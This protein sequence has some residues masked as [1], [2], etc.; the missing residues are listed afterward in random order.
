MIGRFHFWGLCNHP[1][2]LNPLTSC[3][4]PEIRDRIRQKMILRGRLSWIRDSSI[5]RRL[6]S[7]R[8]SSIRRR[9]NTK[10]SIPIIYE[11]KHLVVAN[12]P[13]GVL[14]QE[15]LTGRLYRDDESRRYLRTV[16]RLD[17]VVSGCICVG[18]SSKATSR[19][20]D[21][22]RSRHVRKKYFA[23]VRGELRKDSFE[24]NTLI[25]KLSPGAG[26]RGLTKESCDSNAREAVLM[27]EPIEMIRD[28]FTNEPCTLLD[29]TLVTGI[30]HQ[31][32]AQLASIGHHIINDTRYDTS[33]K[34]RSEYGV[35]AL[36]SYLL[37]FDHPVLG[38][39]PVI[40]QCEIPW[41][42]WQS[43][44]GLTQYT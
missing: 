24:S 39:D 4:T 37:S 44:M 36:H 27:V 42:I 15:E 10:S 1:K 38:H 8:D 9:F 31:I 33:S 34:R 18:K 20:S 30:K 6:S 5:P 23:A 40:A 21:A 17:R 16:H 13:H 2:N 7:I 41:D 35:I 29:I 12:K 26:R 25:H 43:Q 22:F 28:T 19:L 3:E 32:R 14:S 11:D